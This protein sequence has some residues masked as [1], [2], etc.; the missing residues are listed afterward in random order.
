MKDSIK[1]KIDFKFVLFI[2]LLGS[3]LGILKYYIVVG[4]QPGHPLSLCL[5]IISFF[6]FCP[7]VH[8]GLMLI[9]MSLFQVEEDEKIIK[10][11]EGKYNKSSRTFFKW[12]PLA[13]IVAPIWLVIAI[14]PESLKI[15]AVILILIYCVFIYKK[16]F[17]DI[18]SL[19]DIEKYYKNCGWWLMPYVILFGVTQ[20]IIKYLENAKG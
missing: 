5:I 1:E 13:L 3:W 19:N 9:Y 18:F 2:T 12:W 6:V 15:V 4:K 8:I 20:Y 14:F 10:E 16:Y 7:L 11:I 17:K